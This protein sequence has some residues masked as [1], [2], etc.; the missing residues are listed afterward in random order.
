MTRYEKTIITVEHIFFIPKLLSIDYKI[1]WNCKD[2]DSVLG[3]KR[4]KS[5]KSGQ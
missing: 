5:D 1:Q 2:E 3:G 4:E